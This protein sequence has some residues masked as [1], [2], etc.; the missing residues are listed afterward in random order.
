MAVAV[1]ES[2]E[3]RVAVNTDNIAKLQSEQD[4]HRLRLHK[5][6]SGYRGV[7]HLTRM[8]AD[9]QA[10]MP[11]LARQAAR[12]AVTE[13]RRARH[14]DTLSNLRTYAAVFSAGA[15]LCALVIAAVFH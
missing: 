12:E 4:R 1:P 14:S 8:V 3:S 11:N 7:E 10:D 2:V 5:L 13:A 6:E 9:L 15:A